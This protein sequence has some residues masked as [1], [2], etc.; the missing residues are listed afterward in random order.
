VGRQNSAVIN[1]H[2]IIQG[3]TVCEVHAPAESS[4]LISSCS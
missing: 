1:I 2:Q 4:L 3:D